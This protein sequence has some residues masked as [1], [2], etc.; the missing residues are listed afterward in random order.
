MVQPQYSPGEALNRVKLMMGYDSSKT[1]NENKRV[2]FE[3]NNSDLEYFET[4][5]KSVMK[6]PNQI[7]KI[8]F[9]NP[10]ANVKTAANAIKKSV[11]GLGT[12]FYGLDFIIQNGF[13]NISNSM[14]I[15]KNYPSIGGESLFDA[16]NSEF[17]AG[18]KMNKIVSNVSNQ[19]MEWCKTKQNIE[20]CKP[21]SKDEL[22]Y[23]KI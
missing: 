21:K 4:A 7:S 15:I 20:I 10:T 19:L 9:G 16:L 23:G 14:S 11:D 12:D 13:N 18:G 8:N 22:K 1:L 17:F 2:I 6:T 5:A 3:Q